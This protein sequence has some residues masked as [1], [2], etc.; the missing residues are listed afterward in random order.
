MA[1]GAN[2]KYLRKTLLKQ[3]RAQF[4]GN[5]GVGQG[6]I[7]N[8]ERECLARPEQ[9]EPLLR[10]ICKTYNVNYEWL[11]TGRGEVFAGGVADGL[12]S[13]ET[14]D[15]K[16]TLMARHLSEIPEEDRKLLIDSIE[17]TIELYF[18]AKGIK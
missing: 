17:N 5:L 9:K 1:F 2:I 13:R 6:V 12:A 3:T 8:I 4:G 18:K 11:T 15:P 16:I 10:L 14:G 7:N